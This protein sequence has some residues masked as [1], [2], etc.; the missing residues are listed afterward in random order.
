MQKYHPPLT[1]IFLQH[2]ANVGSRQRFFDKLRMSGG[3]GSE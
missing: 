3:N 2:K 1:L